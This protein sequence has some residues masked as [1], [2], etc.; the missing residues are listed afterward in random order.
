ML[1]YKI[2]KA[3]SGTIFFSLASSTQRP[4]SS[5]RATRAA[6]GSHWSATEEPWGWKKQ[7]GLK[8]FDS[9]WMTWMASSTSDFYHLTPLV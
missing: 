9:S 4:A 1:P 8:P 3:E 6:V 7:N 2:Y 5:P